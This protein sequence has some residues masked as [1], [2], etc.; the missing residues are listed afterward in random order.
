MSKHG[1]VKRYILE[2]EKINNSRY[3][4]FEQIKYYLQDHGFEVSK[5]TIQRDIEQIRYEFG[6]EIKYNR[7]E[8]GYYIDKEM[9]INIE[10]FFR[11]LEIVNT[12]ELL[13][14]SLNE[15]KHALKYIS[16]DTKGEFTGIHHLKPLL[17]ATRNHR[18]ISFEHYNFHTSKIVQYLL[19]PYLLK[20][21]QNRWYVVGLIE[22]MKEFRTFG[23]DR[24]RKLEV[25][26]ETFKVNKNL[27]PEKLFDNVI[28][29]V[30][31]LGEM[32]R[33]VL[34]F[35]PVQ[36]KYIKTLPLHHSQQI[37]VDNDK[38]LRIALDIISNYELT[39]EIL[40]YSDTV[41]VLEPKWL[42]DEIKTTLTQALQK[43]K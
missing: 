6:I 7:F 14:E 24:I 2:I 19:K 16:F 30:Y 18:K 15:S 31:S 8:N 32:E 4:S 25:K 39:Q 23:I 35:T 29:L 33:V 10:A 1:T 38:E 43:Y 40:K 17:N 28:G 41:K 42:A 36:G 11:F 9:S 27:K 13:T 20:E 5:R 3:P 34:S 26:P 12:A 22:G 37:L 21:Y